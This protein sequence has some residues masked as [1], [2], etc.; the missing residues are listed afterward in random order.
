MIPLTQLSADEKARRRVL[1]HTME[2]LSR[3]LLLAAA[4]G[5]RDDA[6]RLQDLMAQTPAGPQKM[7][8]HYA[9]E[10]YRMLEHRY[11]SRYAQKSPDRLEPAD[12]LA[13]L[14]QLL[15]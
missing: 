9:L 1:A 14:Y 3:F 8:M 15:P 7:R 5:A 6:G 13:R 11:L 10:H 4:Q 2:F 12:R